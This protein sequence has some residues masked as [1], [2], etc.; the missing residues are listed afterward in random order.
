MEDFPKT[1]STEEAMLESSLGGT[2]WLKSSFFNI[3]ELES[4]KEKT[5][6]KNSSTISIA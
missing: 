5:K 1:K 2:E 4:M 6:L 3:N